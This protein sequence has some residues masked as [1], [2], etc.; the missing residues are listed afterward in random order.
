MGARPALAVPADG[1]DHAENGRRM[2]R[3]ETVTSRYGCL[4]EPLLTGINRY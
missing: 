4:Y 1:T 3:Y 2:D